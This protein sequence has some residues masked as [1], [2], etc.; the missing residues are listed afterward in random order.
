MCELLVL[1]VLLHRGLLT[2]LVGS[3]GFNNDEFCIDQDGVRSGCI[4][5][6]GWGR[7]GGVNSEALVTNTCKQF[8]GAAGCGAR[9][10]H[11]PSS[12]SGLLVVGGR[13]MGGLLEV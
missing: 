1:D 6:R 4:T 2:L 7:H 5:R 9:P 11:S 12:F 13:R 8:C 10:S 3:D